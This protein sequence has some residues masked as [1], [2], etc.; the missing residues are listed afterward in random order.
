MNIN[1][2]RVLKEILDNMGGIAAD[3]QLNNCE[4]LIDKYNAAQMDAMLDK[5]EDEVED[6]VEVVRESRSGRKRK[7]KVRKD[8]GNKG[9]PRR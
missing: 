3:N 5:I 7:K 6:V 4:T 8:M 1:E 2:R 9:V